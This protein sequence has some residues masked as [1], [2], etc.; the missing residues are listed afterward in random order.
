[1]FGTFI[2]DSYIKD[3]AKG[4]ADS[5]DEICSPKD[6]TGWASSGIYSFWNYYT[7]EI[8]YIGLAI[9]LAER[10]KQ[11][12]GMLPISDEAYKYHQI[13]DYFSK[14]Q[15]LGYSIFVHSSLAQAKTHRNQLNIDFDDNTEWISQ[16]SKENIKII[17]GSFIEALKK[18]NNNLPQWNKVGGSDIGRK[19]VSLEMY[20]QL[21]GCLTGNQHDP[22]VARSSIREIANNPVFEWYEI[23]LHSA[24]MGMLSRRNAFEQAITEQLAI[25]PF[26]IQVYSEIVVANYL[27]NH[28]LI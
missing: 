18:R 25:N 1:M 3:E 5:L 2:V 26:F 13:T 21:V 10:F 16:E 8:Y 19:R 7:K 27:E 6:L 23:N 9:D 24:R 4:I 28:P 20:D 22:L 12:N 14:N 17:E 15:K 11:H